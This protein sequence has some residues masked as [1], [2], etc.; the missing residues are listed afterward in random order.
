MRHCV[1]L[2]D[3]GWREIAA[4]FH[5]DLLVLFGSRATGRHRARSD[6]DLAVLDATS[7][8]NAESRAALALE[9]VQLL[10]TDSI[11][12]V[13]LR[14]ASPLLRY[15][16]LRR[17]IVLYESAPRLYQRCRWQACKLWEDSR[18]LHR[19]K[20]RRIDNFL[21]ARGLA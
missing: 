10:G 15:N 1:D 17:C 11:D 20:L 21:R 12:L 8:L 4:R 16:A 3:G 19:A 13:F 6:F 2:E 18:W 9:L 7:P 14:R 5:L